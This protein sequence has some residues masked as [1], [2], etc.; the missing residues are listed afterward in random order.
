MITSP[1]ANALVLTGPTA[2]GKSALALEL[3]ERMN[4]EIIAAD[5]MT[6]YRQ[7]DI[8]TAKPSAADRAR[9]PHH[10][11]DVLDPWESAS[12]AWWLERSEAVVADIERRGKTALFVGGT[13]F[14]LKALLCGLFPSPP[15]DRE[16]RHRLE[17][18][19][20]TLGNQALHDRL[21]SVDPP[22]AHRLHPNDVRRVVRALEVWHLT[23]KPI[24]AWQQQ[25]WW[26]SDNPRFRPGSCLV[27]DVPRE[28]L[29]ARIDRRVEAMF[30]AGWIDEVRRLRALPRPLSREASQAL[31]YREIGDYLDGNRTLEA[32]IAEVQ[33][34]TR[35]F[36]K[37][38][39]TWFRGLPGVEF[40]NAK[41][42]FER[43]ATTITN[44][45]PGL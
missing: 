33:L 5:S 13:P 20:T 6:V 9:V 36:A 22:T 37:R 10:L 35:Q 16:L 31:G 44:G 24:S 17:G 32:T 43:W 1:F 11:I 42:T 8:G 14:Y 28:E 30:A 2:S 3:A 4:G 29:Y 18:E 19:A 27:V 23:G 41:L 21:A 34:R 26:D 38:Q 7:M 39:L 12:V 25:E 40:C 45:F 15:A